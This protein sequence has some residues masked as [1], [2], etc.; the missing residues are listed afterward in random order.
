MQVCDPSKLGRQVDLL[1]ARFKGKETE[2]AAKVVHT[3]KDRAPESACAELVR[4]AKEMEEIASMSSA[5]PVEA[6]GDV[7]GT[8]TA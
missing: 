8:S 5:S 2:L 4:T 1:M 6:G 7:N 3:Y